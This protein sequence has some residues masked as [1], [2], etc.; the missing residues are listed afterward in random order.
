MIFK[1]GSWYWYYDESW[2]M[3]FWTTAGCFALERGLVWTI[4]DEGTF[5][6]L[7]SN[8]GQLEIMMLAISC[9]NFCK[10]W[11]TEFAVEFLGLVG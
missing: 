9:S 2:D 7:N 1:D 4:Y 11:S 6:V 5:G 3:R 8:L 10:G